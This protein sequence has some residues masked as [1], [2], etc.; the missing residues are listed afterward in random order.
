[1]AISRPFLLALLGAL[2]LGATLFAVQNARNN[3]ADDAAPVAQQS[4]PEQQA[5]APSEPAPAANPQET[6]QSA[7]NLGKIDSAA[8]DVTLAV[9]GGGD[10]GT[11]AVSGAFQAGAANDLPELE[12]NT[13]VTSRT[14]RGRGGFVA[15]DDAAYFTQGEK[16]WRV[17]DEVWGPFV[18]AAAS[19]QGPS[20]Q[21]LPV[22]LEPQ[23][24]VTDPKVEGTETIDGV[25]TT[26]VSASIDAARVLRDLDAS[27]P[28][29][30]LPNRAEVARAVKKAELN[31]WVGADDGIVRRLA[32]LVAVVDSGERGAVALDVK[33]SGVNEPQDIKAPSNVAPGRPGG[34]LGDLAETFVAGVSSADGSEPVSLAALT[35]RNPQRAA[36]AVK[37]GKKVVIFF[38]NPKG[39]DDRAM[40]R[41]VRAVDGRTKALVLT[42]HVDAVELYGKM[43]EDLGV[44]QTPAVVLIDS[45]GDARLIEGYVDTDTLAQAVADAR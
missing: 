3:S 9:R 28:S 5:A 23:G 1:M 8:F 7:L 12:V 22:P 38:Q 14:D 24:W 33:L 44:S 30:D 45:T 29:I 31:A 37:G 4:T 17:P 41:V 2:L 15:V 25:E 43:V 34:G 16:A 18:Q 20:L 10:P 6:M 26:H 40:R 35:S 42:D 27:V 36:R 19:G 32:V 39:L 21:N 13:K 11:I